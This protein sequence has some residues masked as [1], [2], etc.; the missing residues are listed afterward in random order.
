MTPFSSVAMLEKL[1]LLKIAFCR[2]P[3]FRPLSCSDM[4]RIVPRL[5]GAALCNCDQL[6]LNNSRTLP[7]EVKSRVADNSCSPDRDV[8]VGNGDV[9]HDGRIHS[10]PACV[11][12]RIHLDPLNPRPP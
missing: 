8:V 2:A 5:M 10:H 11:G 6:C 3:A 1:A 9:V 12:R 7:T 4:E